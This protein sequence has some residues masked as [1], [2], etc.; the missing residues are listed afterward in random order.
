MTRNANINRNYTIDILK[1]EGILLMILG[2]TLV[3]PNIKIWI[4]G[5]HMPLFFILSGYV[6]N[7]TKWFQK[8]FKKFI[9]SRLK[10]LIIPYCCFFFINL[11]I[12]L[13]T[14]LIGSEFSPDDMLKYIILGGGYSYDI[15]MPNCAPI[16]F[17]TT[18]FC[19]SI[20]FWF[21]TKL[22]NTNIKNVIIILQ[23]VL[24]YIICQILPLRGFNQ[25]PWHIDVALLGSVFMLFGY[26]YKSI[27]IHKISFKKRMLISCIFLITASIIIILNG[28]INMVNNEYQNLILFI[29]GA[30]MMFICLHL[31][32]AELYI[33]FP[34]NIILRFLGYIGKRTLVFIGFN[35]VINSILLKITK[36]LG[37]DNYIYNIIDIF[38]VTIIGIILYNGYTYAKIKLTPK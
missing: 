6:F 20:L 11:G 30:L 9:Q 3:C 37:W 13:L 28:R 26:K 7:D 19:S 10:Y 16:W 33:R 32:T 14:D 35:F 23:L 21:L 17:L 5:F 18:L 24:L 38:I 29:I 8:G 25:L 22:K 27:C 4:Y 34:Q 36:A 2:H 15:F 31:L 1:G 12:K